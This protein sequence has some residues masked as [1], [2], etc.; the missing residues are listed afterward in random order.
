M[1]QL[2]PPPS[3]RR[4]L[5][6]SASTLACSA[7]SDAGFSQAVTVKVPS[8]LHLAVAQHVLGTKGWPEEQSENK[9]LSCIAETKSEYTLSTC[10]TWPCSI[11]MSKWP[12]D[13]M[14]IT[15]ITALVPY[16]NHF[17][18]AVWPWTPGCSHP[19]AINTCL[20]L[21]GLVHY[22]TT[23]GLRTVGG[24]TQP[25]ILLALNHHWP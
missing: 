16:M 20:S 21:L 7:S 22:C 19:K 9:W 6:C 17:L 12:E 3:P 24:L 18:L 23:H 13:M 4:T 25:H 2:P 11:V 14:T 8:A 1:T 15:L 10:W 5:A